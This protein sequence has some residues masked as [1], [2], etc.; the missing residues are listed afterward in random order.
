[1]HFASILEDSL[2]NDRDLTPEIE[3]KDNKKRERILYDFSNKKIGT[4]KPKVM[5]ESDQRLKRIIV[6][7]ESKD[8]TGL[9][10]KISR[11]ISN[12]GFDINFARITT[13]HQL[14]IDTF[15]IIPINHAD[16]DL[17]KQVNH[18]SASL[19]KIIHAE[20]IPI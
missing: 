14:A 3:T 19:H 7:V 6:Q 13:E 16:Y 18:L 12:H 15:H 10:Y 4:R 20:I 17:E 9:L 1:M 8:E 2:S 11:S 5:L